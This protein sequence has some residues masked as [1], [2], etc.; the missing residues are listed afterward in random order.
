MP[1][2]PNVM[3]PQPAPGISRTPSRLS[4]SLRSR[5]GAASWTSL[6][7]V[8]RPGHPLSTRGPAIQNL[9][10]SRAAS[11]SPENAAPRSDSQLSRLRAQF[12]QQTQDGAGHHGVEASATGSANEEQARD[13][14]SKRNG[15]VVN[16]APE[17]DW[18]PA[19]EGSRSS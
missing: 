9:E 5:R 14:A 15:G 11:R 17:R 2:Y 7:Q 10:Q 3:E 16:E 1:Q 4:S 12:A 6:P 8:A 19:R 18:N 13:V